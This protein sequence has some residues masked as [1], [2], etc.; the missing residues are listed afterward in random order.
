[1]DRIIVDILFLIPC[2]LLYIDNRKLKKIIKNY[3]RDERIRRMRH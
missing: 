3:R 1:M 2:I